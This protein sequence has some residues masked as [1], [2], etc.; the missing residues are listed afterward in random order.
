MNDNRIIEIWKAL[1]KIREKL[2]KRYISMLETLNDNNDITLDDIYIYFDDEEIQEVSKQFKEINI[3]HIKDTV[4]NDK[5][6]TNTDTDI[7]IDM[8][9]EQPT[10]NG[11]MKLMSGGNDFYNILLDMKN[12]KSHNPEY[13]S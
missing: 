6:D 7:D 9:M 12:T 10:L 11:C 13:D 4:K 5:S 1:N 3:W 2:N 8:D